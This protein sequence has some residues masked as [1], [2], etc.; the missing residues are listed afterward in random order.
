MGKLLWT[1]REDIGPAARY[2]SGMAYDT[3]RHQVALFGGWKAGPSNDTW[4]W[5]GSAWA[6]LHPATSPPARFAASMSWDPASR[7][8]IMFGG[9]PFGGGGFCFGAGGGVPPFGAGGG[10][11]GGGV[12]P[13]GAGVGAGGGVPLGAGV[14]GCC[15]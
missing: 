11:L 6:K 4:V 8:L 7:R 15:G 3:T 12:P 5:N 14:V 9:L 2:Q 1:E 10:L 13:L